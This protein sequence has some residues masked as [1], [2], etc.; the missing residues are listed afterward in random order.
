MTNKIRSFLKTLVHQ[1]LSLGR[2]PLIYIISPCLTKSTSMRPRLEYSIG[3]RGEQRM[4]DKCTHGGTLKRGNTKVQS[5]KL[6]RSI[7]RDRSSSRITTV[8]RGVSDLCPGHDGR[9]YRQRA[10]VNA[11]FAIPWGVERQV[12]IKTIN[13][14]SSRGSKPSSEQLF[15]GR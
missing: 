8:R 5:L 10:S 4:R 11:I 12:D 13:L 3:T 14:R 6:G 1:L 15:H 9:E 7:R 2:V